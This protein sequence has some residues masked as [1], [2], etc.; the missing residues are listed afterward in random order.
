MPVSEKELLPPIHPGE[1]IKEDVL[2]PLGMSV[3]RL[4]LELRVPVS[5]LNEIVNG[6]RSITADTALRLGRYLGIS[7]Q[8]WLN[9]QAAY[10]LEVA[11]RSSIREIKRQVHPRR[12]AA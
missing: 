4:A 12:D 6:R 1:I 8:V 10:E 3:N 11:E 2:R 5:R 9:L 7:A